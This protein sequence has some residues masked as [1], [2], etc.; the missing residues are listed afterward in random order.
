MALGKIL[1][2]A[3]QFGTSYIGG[4]KRLSDLEKSQIGRAHV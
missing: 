4:K 2:G 1:S 3:A